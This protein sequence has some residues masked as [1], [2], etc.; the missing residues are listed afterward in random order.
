MAI[1]QTAAS[2]HLQDVVLGDGGDN[3]VVGRVP[4]EVGDLAGM[5]AV[6]KQ[7]LGGPVLRLLRILHHGPPRCKIR[8]A[9]EIVR[10]AG[11]S[12]AR[13]CTPTNAETPMRGCGSPLSVLL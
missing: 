10:C 13:H 5:P 12:T 9:L 1:S 3:P 8:S 11:S 4:S 7:Q 6:D 2:S